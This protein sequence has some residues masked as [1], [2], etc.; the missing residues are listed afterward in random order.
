MNK[1][2]EEQAAHFKKAIDEVLAEACTLASTS[3]QDEAIVVASMGLLQGIFQQLAARAST[4]ATSKNDPSQRL[5][6]SRQT[7][8]HAP[9]QNAYATCKFRLSGVHTDDVPQNQVERSCGYAKT[10]RGS[11]CRNPSHK[12]K[13]K[14]LMCWRFWLYHISKL[15]PTQQEQEQMDG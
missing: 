10:H 8:T 11:P 15:T 12:C 3:N 4:P 5:C 7:H 6:L 14:K 9:C 1:R 13:I 2:L